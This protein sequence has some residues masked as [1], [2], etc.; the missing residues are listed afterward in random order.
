LVA[1][2]H[3]LSRDLLY[4]W[5]KENKNT[6]KSTQKAKYSVVNNDSTVKA[7][8]A[9]ND[10]LKKLLGEKDLEIAIL[11]DLLIKQANNNR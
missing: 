6:S 7:L 3:N 1:R 2:Q 4:R 5:M 11:R 9:E 8:E 10:T